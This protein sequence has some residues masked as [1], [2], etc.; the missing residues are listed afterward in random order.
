MVQ[1][2]LPVPL[3]KTN[4]LADCQEPLGK[5]H[6]IIA[7]VPAMTYWIPHT[8]TQSWCPKRRHNRHVGIQRVPLKPQ[9][10][11]DKDAHLYQQANYIFHTA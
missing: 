2:K 10:Y 3:A 7:L 1:E 6:K 4:L 5:P 8:I 9:I 11:P